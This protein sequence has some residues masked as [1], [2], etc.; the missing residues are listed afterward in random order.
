MSIEKLHASTCRSLLESADKH[1]L[2]GGI[3]ERLRQKVDKI[4]KASS[5]D[6]AE[7]LAADAI[8]SMYLHCLASSYKT[9]TAR[10]E[11]LDEQ[12][13]IEERLAAICEQ[14]GEKRSAKAH[15][16]N[17]EKF[18]AKAKKMREDSRG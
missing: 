13:L 6:E 10:A 9:G 5:Y 17:A 7:K 8:D 18:R 14:A 2:D 11:R 15:L 1:E 4:L 12:A 3:P 16:G